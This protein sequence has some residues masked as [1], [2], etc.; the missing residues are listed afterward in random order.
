[1][2]H[3][4]ILP[5]GESGWH[6]KT[7]GD[8]PPFSAHLLSIDTMFQKRKKKKTPQHRFQRLLLEK[9]SVQYI[10]QG[11]IHFIFR[12]LISRSSLKMTFNLLK[13][14]Q[15]HLIR[16]MQQLWFCT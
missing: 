1:M 7:P 11:K 4:S 9:P 3:A 8:F 12:Q 16:K 6:Q 15:K 10:E 5:P 14:I 2:M 13:T